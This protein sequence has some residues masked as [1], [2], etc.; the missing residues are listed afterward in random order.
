MS[1]EQY[2]T[3]HHVLEF[4]PLRGRFDLKDLEYSLESL[5]GVEQ[6]L[7][8]RE[9]ARLQAAQIDQIT[10]E[11]LHQSYL[12]PNHARILLGLF[13]LARVVHSCRL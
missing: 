5:V 6:V 7:I 12:H 13:Q 11:R 1:R 2:G 8:Q 9:N 4:D 3:V 10:N